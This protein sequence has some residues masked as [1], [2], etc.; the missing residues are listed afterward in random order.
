MLC[1][2]VE[3]YFMNQDFNG[4]REKLGDLSFPTI[5]LFKFIV[6]SDVH[7]IAQIESLFN[8]KRAQI[9][10][11]ESSKGNYVSISAKEVMLSVDE[12]IDIYIKSSKIN[13]V[14]AL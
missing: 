5:Y 1:I 14:I 2:F 8:S 7:K 3:N 13:G 10:L 12:I 6:K 9:R 4:L 11:T